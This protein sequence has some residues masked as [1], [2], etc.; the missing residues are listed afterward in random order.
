MSNQWC[1]QDY[2]LRVAA[3]IWGQMNQ[4]PKPDPIPPNAMRV[5]PDSDA[6]VWK[7]C[8]GDGVEI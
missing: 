7:V 4:A 3:S 8:P 2:L 1:D 5:G 6:V